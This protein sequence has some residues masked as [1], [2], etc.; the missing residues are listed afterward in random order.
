[1]KSN[2]WREIYTDR[3]KTTDRERETERE[4][5]SEKE[6]WKEREIER[7]RSAFLLFWLRSPQ[8]LATELEIW[9]KFSSNWVLKSVL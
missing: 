8:V 7:E 9:V 4:K 3:E 5:E 2:N 6:R 1:M